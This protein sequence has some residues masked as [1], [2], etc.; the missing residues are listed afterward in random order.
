MKSK[1]LLLL[2]INL[3]GICSFTAQAKK[4]RMVQDKKYQLAQSWM[5]RAEEMLLTNPK[6]ASF[7]A[8]KAAE[9]F[10]EKE[11][12]HV[13]RAEAMIL[14]SKAEQYLGNFDM[15]IKTLYDAE[16]FIPANNKTLRAEW[17]LLAGRLFGKL[18]DYNKAIGLNE[19]ATAIFKSLGDSALIANCYN[20]RGVMHYAQNQFIVAEQFLQRALRINRAQRNLKGIATNLNNLCLYQGDTSE[21]ILLIDEAIVINRNLD[22]K[23]SLGENY[24]NRGKQLF[25]GGR[26]AEALQALDKGFEY[27]CQLGAR[28][29]MCDYYEYS[30][31]VYAAVGQYKKAYENLNQMF[32][33]SRQLTSNNR[34][35]NVEQ[36]ISYKRMQDQRRK[37]ESERQTYNIQLLRQN[38][39]ILIAILALLLVT[40]GFV[41]FWYKRRKNNQLMEARLRLEQSQHEV[42]QL[43]LQQQEQELLQQEHELQHIQ[44]A[45]DNSQREATEFAMFLRSR[46]ELLDK[47]R[48]LIKEGY[49]LD[50]NAMLPHLKRVNAF[51]TQCQN[52]KANSSVLL[53]LEQ[54]NQD[55]T[56]HLQELHPNLTQGERH[57]ATLLRVSMSTKEIAML[58][59]TTPKTVNMNR[60]RLRKALGLSGDEDLEDYIRRL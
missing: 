22:A 20:E 6:E 47:I 11:I 28:E 33:L 41:Y 18:G 51:I 57:L 58:T 27:A 2:L 8:M 37:A 31:W 3:F 30:S 14:H 19:Q 56:T 1:H 50:A 4:N 43:K 10:P 48:D 39:Y 16:L 60:Y 25:Y 55:F 54:K 49:K 52:E 42:S 32:K 13:L 26:H 23:W 40:V 53:H 29:L 12:P 36:E 38:V 17:C 59:G 21:K 46:N 45:L 15:S 5:K 34:L 9:L 24:N 35:R 7:Y 44:N